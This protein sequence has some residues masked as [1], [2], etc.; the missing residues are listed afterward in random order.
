[1]WMSRFDVAMYCDQ[2]VRNVAVPLSL[3]DWEWKSGPELLSDIRKVQPE[4]GEAIGDLLLAYEQWYSLHE[5]VERSGGQGKDQSALIEAIEKRDLAR[6]AV[7]RALHEATN[8][9]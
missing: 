5:F 2:V 7:R 8:A 1:M 9:T 6:G 4:L 3:Q